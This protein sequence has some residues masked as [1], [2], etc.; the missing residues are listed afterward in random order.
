MDF[1]IFLE[2]IEAHFET[3][4]T[5]HLFNVLE[6]ADT[7]RPDE[8][9]NILFGRFGLPQKG[10]EF[11]A[12]AGFVEMLRQIGPIEPFYSQFLAANDD[13][14]RFLGSRAAFRDEPGLAFTGVE[15]DGFGVN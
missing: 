3:I 15:L 14:N 11:R 12:R 7:G 5:R 6:E 2:R 4:I 8:E 9:D 13:E 10:L 1:A